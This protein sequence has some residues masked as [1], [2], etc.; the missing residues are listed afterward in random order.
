MRLLT[1]ERILV[2]PKGRQ[3][4]ST[5]NGPPDNS[6]GGPTQRAIHA[7]RQWS[8]IINLNTSTNEKHVYTHICTKNIESSP[9]FSAKVAHFFLHRSACPRGTHERLD[10]VQTIYESRTRLPA[11]QL[12]QTRY[13]RHGC[14]RST[15]ITNPIKEE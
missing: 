11:N 5:G 10:I 1:A 6:S 12:H 9:M 8:P 3:R 7:S 14:Q 4:F 2:M 15:T 13:L